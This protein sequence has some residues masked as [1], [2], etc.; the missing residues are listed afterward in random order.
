MGDDLGSMLQEQHTRAMILPASGL[1]QPANKEADQHP[2]YNRQD[3][4]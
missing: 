2:Q 1:D 4:G 3:D